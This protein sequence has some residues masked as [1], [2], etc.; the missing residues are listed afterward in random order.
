MGLYCLVG[1]RFWDDH[2]IMLAFDL[3]ESFGTGVE[4]YTSRRYKFFIVPFK[5]VWVATHCC[6]ESLSLSVTIAHSSTK[7]SG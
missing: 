4:A 3:M 2:G 1:Q 6:W 5:T 7:Q